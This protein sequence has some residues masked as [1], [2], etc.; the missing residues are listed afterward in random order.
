M[1]MSIVQTGADPSSHYILKKRGKRRGRGRGK[2]APQC[3]TGPHKENNP[4]ILIISSER[5]KEGKR[6]RE[7]KKK[8][9]SVP[10]TFFSDDKARSRPRRVRKRRRR[11]GEK[12]NRRPMRMPGPARTL[13]Q[14]SRRLQRPTEKKRGKGGGGMAL[15][16]L[17]KHLYS[18]D[19]R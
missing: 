10:A 1:H 13:V 5:K 19:C 16:R 14:P 7:K 8:A 18:A 2:G 3:V 15:G 4:S 17:T 9:R 11:N 12:K 6:K